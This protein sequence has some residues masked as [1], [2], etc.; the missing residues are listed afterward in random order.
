MNLLNAFIPCSQRTDDLESRFDL[1]ISCSVGNPLS[2]SSD[3]F[4]KNVLRNQDPNI[5]T[6][7][8]ISDTL[9]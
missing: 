8:G 6:M 4:C 9:F 7:P 1:E 2:K 5:E 3:N